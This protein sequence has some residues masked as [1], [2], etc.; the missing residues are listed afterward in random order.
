M[1][2]VHLAYG[3]GNRPEFTMQPRTDLP[4]SRA[5]QVLYPEA[6]ECIARYGCEM[7]AADPRFPLG[8]ILQ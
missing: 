7:H 3:T 6:K 5:L 8:A 2:A 4:L 1:L